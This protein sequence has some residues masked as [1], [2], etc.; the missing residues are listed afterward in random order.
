VHEA[1]EGYPIQRHNQMAEAVVTT[2]SSSLYH[3][4]G[5]YRVNRTHK[6][7]SKE[8]EKETWKN[9]ILVESDME[10]NIGFSEEADE[11]PG[12]DVC[13]S[14]HITQY[15]EEDQY[16]RPKADIDTDIV[17]ITPS[18]IKSTEQKKRQ[19]QPGLLAI[20][21]S[22]SP[23]RVAVVRPATVQRRNTTILTPNMSFVAESTI[24]SSSTKNR[25]TSLQRR[26]NIGGIFPT[27]FSTP[28]KKPPRTVTCTTC[29]SDDI[30]H[31]KSAKLECGHRMCQACLKRIFILSTQ[32]PQLMP[33]RCC[34]D[35]GIPLEHVD[36][37]FDDKFKLIW[38]KKY[39]EY[40]TKNRLYCPKKRCGE[41]IEPKHIKLEQSVGRRYGICPKCKTK[42]CK[43]CGL[44]WH[45]SRDCENDAETKRVI[46]MGKEEGWQRC[47]RCRAMVQL[48]EGCNH[49][50]C[51]C[52]AE[53]C[54]LCGKK[55]KTCDC[56]LFNVP[57]ESDPGQRQQQHPVLVDFERMFR[58]YDDGNALPI[59]PPPLPPPLLP[60]PP[61]PPPL[62]RPPPPP[63]PLLRP[64]PP[65]PT[66]VPA[67]QLDPMNVP[68]IFI[69]PDLPL[70]PARSRRQYHHHRREQGHIG[71]EQ[72]QREQ[73]AT[74]EALAQ[75]LQEHE[76]N[77]GLGIDHLHILDTE[78]EKDA[79]ASRRRERAERRE[80]RRQLAALH[81]NGDTEWM[82]TLRPIEVGE[83]AVEK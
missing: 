59:P 65:P 47:Y 11:F 56:P 35:N 54:Y 48:V 38:N 21:G 4:S 77:I 24:S 58:I 40:T 19:R 44:R 76:I 80:R 22:T 60:P 25:R 63:P 33:P 78:P 57:A 7:E 36:R 16:V 55:W 45:G 28:H 6:N 8:K 61:P 34:N 15:W 3:T 13:Q 62:L 2:R 17:S 32:D 37:L 67:V 71:L 1:K 53:F 27:T 82:A 75:L 5:Y 29:L 51:R 72:Q 52:A 70:P 23:Q 49:M 30:P 69:P 74:D 26:K 39:D 12:E 79:I 64:P 41:W 18:S 68:E 20:F 50:R 46:D 66:A 43:R 9:E 73:E 83:G 10:S 14:E 81:E 31:S 42:V